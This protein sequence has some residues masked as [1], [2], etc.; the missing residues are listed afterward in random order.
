MLIV[1]SFIGGEKKMR[2][3]VF[4]RKL[5]TEKAPDWGVVEDRRNK[6]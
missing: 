4:T 2:I 5:P 1:P 3:L 6:V